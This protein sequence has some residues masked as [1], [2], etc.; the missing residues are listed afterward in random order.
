ML[1]LLIDQMQR[2]PC[3]VLGCDVPADDKHTAHFAFEIDWTE[4]VRP[5]DILAAPMPRYRH[6]LVLKP[7]RPVACHDVLDL[8]ANDVPYLI[9]AIAA[10]RS[11]SARMPFRPHSLAIGIVVELDEFRS[12]PNEH[13]M[14]RGENKPHR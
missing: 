9:P 12:P 5:P 14:A 4:A 2:F 8:G 3:H 13:R 6:Q 10:P 1:Q 11:Q 7:G